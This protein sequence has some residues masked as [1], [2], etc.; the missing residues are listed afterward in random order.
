M[1]K[2]Q[3]WMSRFLCCLLPIVLLVM[4]DFMDRN[5]SNDGPLVWKKE[6]VDLRDTTGLVLCG[7]A[8]C[9]VGDR[10][11]G[12]VVVVRVVVVCVCTALTFGFVALACF[13]SLCFGKGSVCRGQFAYRAC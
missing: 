2:K 10:L 6:M 8:W 12:D 4:F 1:A 13:L 11:C 9:A 3:G 5:G 7:L